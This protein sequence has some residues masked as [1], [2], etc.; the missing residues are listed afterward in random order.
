MKQPCF[1]PWAG[2]LPPWVFVFHLVAS[3]F[4]IRWRIDLSFFWPVS[5]FA[6]FPSLSHRASLT[7]RDWR[8]G[9]LEDSWIVQGLVHQIKWERE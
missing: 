4:H 9:V 2:I 8:A 3:H 6:S 7:D 1:C 5:L